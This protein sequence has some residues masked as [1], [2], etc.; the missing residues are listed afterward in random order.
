MWP[1]PS[2]ITTFADGDP[3]ENP[4]VSGAPP[5]ETIE[6]APYSPE[7]P[8]IF[9]ASKELIALALPGIAL[10]FEHVGSTAEQSFL[11]STDSNH[12]FQ[13]PDAGG[14]GATF[15]RAMGACAAYDVTT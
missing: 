11:P 1:P 13:R 9:E 14:C 15:N 8:A 5:V 12:A 3:D 6:I 2:A 4:W 7:W 10:H